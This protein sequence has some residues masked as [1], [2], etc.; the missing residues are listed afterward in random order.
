MLKDILDTIE[1]PELRED[2]EPHLYPSAASASIVDNGKR[3]HIGACLR[4]EWYRLKNMEITDP[5]DFKA[6][7]TMSVGSCIEA[8][9]I[10]YAK[11]AGVYVADH[12][13]IRVERECGGIISGELDLVIDTPDGIRGIEL[14]SFSRQY[15]SLKQI[16]GTGRME[17][18][19]DA[20]KIARVPH[21]NPSPKFDHVMQAALYI[22]M[23]RQPDA[24]FPECADEGLIERLKAIPFF[25]ITYICRDN[26][27]W[28]SEFYVAIS[29]TGT[30]VYK[31]AFKEQRHTLCKIDAILANYDRLWEYNTKELVP[32]KSYEGI[33]NDAKIKEMYEKGSLTKKEEAQYKKDGKLI[34]GDWQCRR[35]P[36]DESGNHRYLYCPY[37]HLCAQE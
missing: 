36:A 30:I 37:G 8:E 7:A 16:M 2:R 20:D 23:L 18:F 19:D 9:V 3:Q 4:R 28:I 11:S 33:Y 13:K 12:I 26:A 21:I 29:G 25:V 34:K 35:T 1:P 22:W 32:P 10:E 14:K 6:K 27:G 24:I 17:D 31:H 15:Y 5:F